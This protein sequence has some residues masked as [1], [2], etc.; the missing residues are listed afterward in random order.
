M[1]YIINKLSQPLA[2]NVND[3]TS[4][5]LFPNEVW[6]L[7]EE[8]LK[9]VEIHNHLRKRNIAVFKSYK[10][11]NLTEGTEIIKGKDPVAFFYEYTGRKSRLGVYQLRTLGCRAYTKLDFEGIDVWISSQTNPENPHEIMSRTLARAYKT[12]I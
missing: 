1:F 7:G 6:M 8:Q 2:L 10:F 9:S 4:L 5:H 12:I 11:N 3:G